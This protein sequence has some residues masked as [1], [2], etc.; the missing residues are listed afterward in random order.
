M[1]SCHQL[2]VLNFGSGQ[3][4]VNEADNCQSVMDGESR[5]SGEGGE[6]MGRRIM[7]QREIFF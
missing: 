6:G 5:V 3:E 7:F 2:P 4:A 1:I